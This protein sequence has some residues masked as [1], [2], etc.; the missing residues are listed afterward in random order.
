MILQENNIETWQNIKDTFTERYKDYCKSK[1]TRG[2][3]FRMTQKE[4]ES[5]KDFEEIFQLRYKRAHSYTLDDDYLKLVLL[6]GVREEC[7]D[8]LNLL[9]HGDI[10]QLS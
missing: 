7:M 4:N 2:E 3:I 8:T 1:D 9:T 6:Q 5:P 10:S